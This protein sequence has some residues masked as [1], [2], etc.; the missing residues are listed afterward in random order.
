MS[1]PEI[2][3][4]GW[5]AAVPVCSAFLPAAPHGHLS[6]F[7]NKNIS[8]D[9]FLLEKGLFTDLKQEF[10]PSSL[11]IRAIQEGS[12]GAAVTLLLPDPQADVGLSTASPEP[13][14]TAVAEE[15]VIIR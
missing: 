4:Y 15:Q 11:F 12:L 7:Q 1:E 6:F 2:F 5:R 10:A 13:L 8:L 14:K 9:L 3:G